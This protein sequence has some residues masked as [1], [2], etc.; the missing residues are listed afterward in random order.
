METKKA[1]II[2]YRNTYFGDYRIHGI[3][4]TLEKAQK[5]FNE[6]D[7]LRN[8]T[9]DLFEEWKTT[10]MTPT[11]T[12]FIDMMNDDIFAFYSELSIVEIDIPIHTTN[13]TIRNN[14]RAIEHIDLD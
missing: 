2:K 11:F 12:G 10:N 8:R 13:E 3:Y 14:I 1:Y 6:M 7:D 9:N 4:G 5:A